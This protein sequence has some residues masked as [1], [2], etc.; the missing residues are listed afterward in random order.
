[1]VQSAFIH[2]SIRSAQRAALDQHA[3]DKN[4][5]LSV[6]LWHL[7][8]AQH[9]KFSVSATQSLTNISLSHS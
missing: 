9:P 8:L 6:A 7:I 2:L 3:Q 4:P 1:M 5:F